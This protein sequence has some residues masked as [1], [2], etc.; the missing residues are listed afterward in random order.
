M[1]F[2]LCLL[3][4][5]EWKN[6]V[7]LSPWSCHFSLD[8]CHHIISINL[9][10][11]HISNL[12]S[13]LLGLSTSDRR[14]CS[15]LISRSWRSLSTI[16]SFDYSRPNSSFAHILRE[17]FVF[18]NFLWILKDTQPWSKLL[19]QDSS[20][21]RIQLELDSQALKNLKG[22]GPQYLSSTFSKIGQWLEIVLGRPHCFNL[23][24]TSKSWLNRNLSILL[25]FSPSWLFDHVYFLPSNWMSTIAIA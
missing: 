9:L 7:F 10:S 16:S 19:D 15:T 8:F 20:I 17:A 4:T 14:P 23:N 24:M 11:F 22:F 1:L 2:L 5:I 18:F 6:L 3:M 13:F 12:N 25:H 21:S